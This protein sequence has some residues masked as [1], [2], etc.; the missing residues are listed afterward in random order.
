[1]TH[2]R[3][4]GTILIVDDNPDILRL[5]K[6]FLENSGYTV[7]TAADGDE[8]LR[9]Y[10]EQHSSIALLLSDVMMPKMNGIELADRVLGMDSQLPFL[11]MSGD[12]G[13]EYRGLECLAKPFQPAELIETVRRV[14][15]AD[16][17]AESTALAG[18]R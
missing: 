14:L 5:A 17:R 7:L 13:Y 4:R 8:G 15:S 2:D 6:I 10:E 3:Q 9:L 11:F 12:A 1:M 18:S 16:R